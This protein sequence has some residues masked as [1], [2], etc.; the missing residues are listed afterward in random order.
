MG[1]DA[2][3]TTMAEEVF[4]TLTTERDLDAPEKPTD[5]AGPLK[6]VQCRLCK[7]DHWTTKCP[8]GDVLAAQEDAGD[9]AS[10]AGGASGAAGGAAGGA[11]AGGKYVPPSLRE[12][13][14]RRGDSLRSSRNDECTLRVSNLSDTT[15]EPEVRDLFSRF[16][17]LSRVHVAMNRELGTSKGFAF[18]SY[19]R[20]EDAQAALDKL[21]GK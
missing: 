17:H 2:A 21:N 3:C 18:I 16:G 8:Y 12:G 20:K 19:T 14:D 4:L 9:N 10:S 13:G 7:G 5:E 11:S 1:P 15:Y 6:M